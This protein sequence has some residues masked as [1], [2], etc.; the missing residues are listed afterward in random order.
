MSEDRISSEVIRVQ[1][2]F[3]VLASSAL[4]DDRTRVLKY[5]DTFAVFNRYGDIETFGKDDLGLFQSETRHLS[6]MVLQLNNQSPLLLGSEICDDNAF[7]SV[8]LTNLDETVDGTQNLARGTIHIYR[9][10]FLDEGI[11]YEHLRV[12]N[13]GVSSMSFSLQFEF[14]ADFADIFEVR[15]AKRGKRGSYEP[16]A[17]D[18][19]S[20]VFNYLGLDNVR[21]TTRVQFSPIPHVLTAKSA[22]YDISLSAREEWTISITVICERNAVPRPVQAY[23]TAFEKRSQQVEQSGFEGCRITTSSKRF[24]KW[25]ARSDA[26]LRM[27]IQG[28]PEGSYP[29][30]GVPWFN[31]VFGR[32]G[33]ITAMECLWMA[34]VISEGVLRYLAETQATRTEPERDAEP[35]KIVHEIRRGEMAALG[36]V[37]F[38][39]YYGSVDSTPLFVMLAGGYFLR[40]NNLKFV[41]SIWPNILRALEWIDHYGDLDGDGFVEYSKRSKHGLSQQGWKD[42]SDSISHANGRL[43]DPPIALCEVQAYVY[44]AKR[45]AALIAQAVG[46]E[47]LA[48]KLETQAAKLQRDFERS[49]W[50][51]NLQS[52]V[53][54]LDGD[55]QQCCVRASNAGH[56]LFCCIASPEHARIVAQTLLS[57]SMFSGWGVRTLAAGEVRYNPMS[58]HNGSVWPHDNALIALGLSLCGFQDLTTTILSGLYESC[59]HMDL[60]R[61][62]ELFCG[63]HRRKDFRDSGGPILY[64]VA[65]SPQTWAAASVYLLLRAVLGINIRAADRTIHFVNPTLPPYLDE[66]GI[67]DLRVGDAKVDLV[68]RRDF[69][70]VDVEVARKEGD[71]EIIKSL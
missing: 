25:L 33:I 70:G 14:D 29:Y 13:H 37:P 32:D 12:T 27:M 47:K 44:A 52:Y 57:E 61:M 51:E 59:L 34:P 21:R 17:V 50:N 42:S 5:G 9:S 31:T 65:C 55:K 69:K 38:G 62:P 49:Y 43:A 54:A 68:I 24:N 8:D 71:I 30:A 66:I 64:P 35:G 15:G 28:N 63:F 7:L 39:R 6:R 46:D 11:C 56:A 1:D 45:S 36:E 23:S 3:Y 67:Q 4:A 58:Y 60:R 40:T 20:A 26:D 18:I 2:K 41:K 48:A 22:Q 16:S 19:D 53:L 10:K